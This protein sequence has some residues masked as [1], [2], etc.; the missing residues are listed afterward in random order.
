MVVPGIY[1]RIGISSDE[2]VLYI[3][4]DE[5]SK[6]E[7]LSRKNNLVDYPQIKGGKVDEGFYLKFLETKGVMTLKIASTL[8]KTKISKIKVAAYG[9]GAVYGILTMLELL[10]ITHD[11]NIYVY[12]YGQPHIGN[13]IFAQYISQIG[14]FLK[15]ARFT[16]K[17]DFVPRM[18]VNGYHDYL[19][20][21]M[22]V[23]IES[24]GCSC[25]ERVYF[26]MGETKEIKGFRYVEESMNCNNQF[27]D[28]NFE[29]HKGPYFGYTMGVCLEELPP[30]PGFSYVFLW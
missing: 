29:S 27:R 4:A 21:I 15:I 7:W 6:E 10:T 26:C 18:P 16:F 30:S 13:R 8:V 9:I 11:I 19:H 14:R 25:D 2:L 3:H 22:E 20:H 5:L 23:W 1:A 12:S 28:A 17:D 24:D